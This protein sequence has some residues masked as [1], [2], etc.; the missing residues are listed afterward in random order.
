[1]LL[2]LCS[3]LVAVLSFELLLLL[4]APDGVAAATAAAEEDDEELFSVFSDPPLLLSFSLSR[5]DEE[6]ECFEE[7]WCRSLDEELERL[8]FDDDDECSLLLSPPPSL[9]P[10]EL[11]ERSVLFCSRDF[12]EGLDEEDEDGLDE[13]EEE[14]GRDLE[15]EEEGS[16]R[17]HKSFRVIMTIYKKVY[18]I[19]T[20]V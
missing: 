3:T 6:D 14:D 16:W 11:E 18:Y 12:E 2:I 9:L 13:E 7:E 4:P 5:L 15:E 10:M 17:R 19:H 8:S 20:V 1:M